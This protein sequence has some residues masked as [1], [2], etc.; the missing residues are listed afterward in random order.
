M[1]NVASR[2]EFFQATL[3]DLFANDLFFYFSGTCFRNKRNV[4]LIIKNPLSFNY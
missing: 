3:L 2:I 1:A 4:V